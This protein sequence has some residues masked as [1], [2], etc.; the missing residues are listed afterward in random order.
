VGG[1]HGRLLHHRH[2]YPDVRGR[3]PKDT[4]PTARGGH[5]VVGWWGQLVRRQ[6]VSPRLEIATAGAADSHGQR[7][8]GVARHRTESRRDTRQNHQSTEK[9][10][11]KAKG[12]SIVVYRRKAS[13]E[14]TAPREQ[15]SGL[16]LADKLTEAAS[17]PVA[18][19]RRAMPT[20]VGAAPG[21]TPPT[22]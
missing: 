6:A 21:L 3:D 15:R 10:V 16:G 13:K 8:P 7:L 12:R 18:Q 11:A 22:G 19:A 9:P 5:S 14:A 2:R 17:L 1:G 4:W 20:G